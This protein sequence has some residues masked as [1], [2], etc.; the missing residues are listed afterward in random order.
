VDWKEALWKA[1][2]NSKT[3]LENI[4][5]TVYAMGGTRTVAEQLGVSQRQVQRWVTANEEKRATPKAATAARLSDVAMNSAGVRKAAVG[6]RRASRMRNNGVGVSGKGT[7]GPQI[8]GKDYRRDNRSFDTDLS[9][10]S[11]RDV[12]EQWE[13][14]ADEA[15]R[16]ALDAA[17]GEEYVSEW[18]FGDTVDEFDLHVW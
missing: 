8:G 13:S 3:P 11:W 6:E 17:F 14:G 18:A 10:D 9:A 5:Q 2:T 1:M 12:Y 4:R 7:G 16:V 15:A